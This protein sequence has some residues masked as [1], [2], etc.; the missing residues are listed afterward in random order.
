MGSLTLGILVTYFVLVDDALHVEER[1]GIY[2]GLATFKAVLEYL[3]D[4]ANQ[5]KCTDLD[6]VQF[7]LGGLL[8]R[9]WVYLLI[10]HGSAADVGNTL[11][12]IGGQPAHPPFQQLL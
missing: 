7:F 11:Q 1:S 5:A 4:Q 8:G 9:L 12:S 3:M 2:S 10:E 6:L